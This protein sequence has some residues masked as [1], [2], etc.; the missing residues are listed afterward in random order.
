MNNLNRQRFTG[1]IDMIDVLMMVTGQMYFKSVTS[2]G[3][4]LICV[5][6]MIMTGM[7]KHKDMDFV[8][9]VPLLVL[10]TRSVRAFM[11]KSQN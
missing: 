7:I 5:Q 9:S 3:C 6:R 11:K 2:Y 1:V 10:I 4:I 8:T